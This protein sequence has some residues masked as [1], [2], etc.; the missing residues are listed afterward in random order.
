MKTQF[1]L[2]AFLVACSS[3]KKTEERHKEAPA[4]VSN[5]SFKKEK[6]LKNTEV[7]DFYASSTATMNPALQ[8]ETLDRYTAEEIAEMAEGNDPLMEIS[9]RCSRGDFNNAFA[10]AAKYFQKYQKVAAYWNQVANCHLNQGS[11]RK[12]L[13]FYNKALEVKADYVPALNN[14]GVMYSRMDQDQK[15]LI[16]FE[17]ANKASKFAKTPRYNLAKLYLIYGLAEPALPI[18][19]GLLESS[20]NDVDLRNSVA[21]VY[22]LM[23][24]YNKAWEHFQQIPDGQWSRADIGLNL[25]VTL[26][27]LGKANEAVK[28]FE[29]V[30]KP[31]SSALSKYYGTVENYL[32]EKQ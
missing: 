1:L 15:A 7:K 9:L 18:L 8:D 16:A 19:N 30:Q 29:S 3:S 20:P 11:Y 21:N 5:Q 6:A 27:K 25:A 4:K 2:L 10:V 31:K 32:G 14:I 24:D 12:A 13:L 26:K 23:S 17:R 22:F 28:V